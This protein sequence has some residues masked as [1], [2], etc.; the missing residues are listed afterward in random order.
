MSTLSTA[1]QKANRQGNLALMI[2]AIPNFPDPETYKEILNLLETHPS[3]TLIET[4]LP[5]SNGF[6]NFANS[7]IRNA[8]THAVQY[9]DGISLLKDLRPFTKPS[10]L[11]LYQ[12]TL[13]ALGYQPLLAK[14]QGKIDGVL[15]EWDAHGMDDYAKQ[16][17]AFGIELIQC[18]ATN[19]SDEE[20][21][22]YMVL[23]DDQPLVYLVSAAMT[24]AELFDMQDLSVCLEKVK[25][26]RPS[27][28]VLAGFGVRSA[29]DIRRLSSVK[30][31]DGVIIGT[32]FIE[33]MSKG[34]NAVREFLDSLQPALYGSKLL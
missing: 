17:E 34:K 31:L 6:S 8:H 16:S 9:G 19:M 12:Q 29:E 22:G 15:F 10:V 21:H 24:G 1:V 23:T 7:V 18:A 27:A 5:V 26:V 30:G 13:D 20:L 32:A 33:I 11:V 14:I 3:V 2:Y 28:K 4:T 25:Q